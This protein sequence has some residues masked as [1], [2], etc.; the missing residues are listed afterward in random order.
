LNG[1]VEIWNATNSQLL[2]TLS[3]HSGGIS[4]IA[5]SRDGRKIAT[6]SQDQSIRLWNA[7]NGTLLQTLTGHIGP[8]STVIWDLNGTRII[9]TGVEEQPNLRIWDSATGQLIRGDPEGSVAQMVWSPDGTKLALVNPFGL[10]NFRDPTSL[11]P[12]IGNL[13]QPERGTYDG[14]DTY[15][16]AWSPDSQRIATGSK[17]GVVRVWNVATRRSVLNLRGNDAKIVDIEVSAINSLA[18]SADN[19][20]LFS[21]STGGTLRIWNA[22]TGQIL[23]T[24]QIKAPATAYDVA[25]S[26]DGSKI[27]YGTT[28][29]GIQIVSPIPGPT[30]TP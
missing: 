6:A 14:Y 8:V 2:N 27:A 17:N 18:F 11:Q 23:Q 22:I 24:R 30:T 19:T 20:K 28:S 25:W 7:A 21:T 13:E 16:V 10:V 9:S 29:G 15:T 3:G 5:W 1:V 26:P 12:I 4:D